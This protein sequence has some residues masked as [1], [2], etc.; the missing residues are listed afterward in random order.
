MVVGVVGEFF[1]GFAEIPE[2]LIVR[3]FEAD[4]GFTGDGGFDT[5]FEGRAVEGHFAAEGVADHAY[6]GGIDIGAGE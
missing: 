4:A 2:V 1:D 5:F 6:V 3:E